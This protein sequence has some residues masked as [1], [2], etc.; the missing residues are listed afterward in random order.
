MAQ[1]ETGSQILHARAARCGQQQA[2]HLQLCQSQGCVP[3]LLLPVLQQCTA[4]I[5]GKVH[6]AYYHSA[7]L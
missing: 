4:N 6:S 7:A 5:V 1:S 3:A 2:E